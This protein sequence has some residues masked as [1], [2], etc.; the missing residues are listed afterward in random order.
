MI[1]SIFARRISS[2]LLLIGFV[3]L[4]V[5]AAVSVLGY[6]LTFDYVMNER[7]ANL[8]TLSDRGV[9]V[10]THFQA[11]AAAGRLAEDRAKAQA[12]AL[13]R[14]MRK[15]DENYY[16]IDDYGLKSVLLPIRPDLEGTDV[17]HFRDS[18]G[19]YYVRKQK[20]IAQSGGGFIAYEF[21]RAD[22]EAAGQKLSY[23]Q[24]F[25]P[26]GWFIGIGVY[27]DDVHR[28]MALYI[29]RALALVIAVAAMSGLSIWLV[30]RQI[31][32]PLA[33]LRLAIPQLRNAALTLPALR[34]ND[35]I[36]DIARSL[37][38]YRATLLENDRL[39]AALLSRE[40]EE[41]R[42]R[43]EEKAR[44]YRNA[45]RLEQTARLVT[46][47]EVALSIAHELNQPLSA[48]HHY[49]EGALSRLEK[50]TP[51]LPAIRGAMERASTQARRA[52]QTI[53]RLRSFLDRPSEHFAACSL[54][55][56]VA[57]VMRSAGETEGLADLRIENTIPAS[58]PAFHG[59][60]ILIQQVLFNLI[61]NGVEAATRPD[62][63]IRI[64]AR[65]R[66]DGLIECRVRDDG[67]GVPAEHVPRLFVAFVTTKSGGMGVGLN[68][69]RSIIEHHGGSL[70][71][72]T[73][74]E[75]G[76]A[77]CF[78]L[79]REGASDAESGLSD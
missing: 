37:A 77:F 28:Q 3:N 38:S 70:W 35:E 69:C 55:E 50:D 19:L 24:P 46:S 27:L 2:R 54:A 8:R 65:L 78:T 79:R 56:L 71:H 73:P 60:P 66:D 51:D 11:L 9:Q 6:R 18:T 4:L 63:R 16:F 21:Y 31:T 39:Q 67:P 7:M 1:G 30:A 68:I 17:S 41:R 13:L 26:W 25:E 10:L 74:D 29:W 58:L 52:S 53:A 22:V 75:G 45:L 48:V 76:A 32:R 14:E 36:G 49:C 59:D 43:E 64:S 42:R 72:E 57:D 20:E 15:G 61:R 34:R 40:Q 44:R 23:I 47:G 5:L 33:Q 62:P 12:V